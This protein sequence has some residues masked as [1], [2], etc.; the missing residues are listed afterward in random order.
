MSDAPRY[1]L[2]AG[3]LPFDAY[4]AIQRLTI[5]PI[6]RM[7]PWRDRLRALI[8]SCVA[9]AAIGVGLSVVGAGLEI[10]LYAETPP[11]DVTL[12][13]L[14][15]VYLLLLVALAG[16]VAAWIQVAAWRRRV[17]RGVHAAAPHLHHPHE[18]LLSEVGVTWSGPDGRSEYPWAVIAG[19]LRAAGTN[20]LVVSRMNAL[21]FDA[22]EGPEGEAALAYVRERVA[23]A[24]E[25]A[26]P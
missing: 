22:V 12:T 7:R 20:L 21:W 2:R 14:S 18:L 13:G 11:A 6:A 24:G 17:L 9:G 15:A 16:F 8:L 19:P 25:G 10:T 26:P 3:P 1:R 23:A 4:A 5:G